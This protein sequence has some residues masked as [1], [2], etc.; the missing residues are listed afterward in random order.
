MPRPLFVTIDG[1]GFI[2]RHRET[3]QPVGEV[4]REEI[5]ESYPLPFTASFIAGEIDEY[6]ARFEVEEAR[7]ILSLDNVE[8]AS[9]SWSHPHDWTEPAIDLE[10]E[11]VASAARIER[12]LL[13]P[14]GR[15][16]LMLWTGMC[17]PT[18]AA[19]ALADALGMGNLNGGDPD[20]AF[21]E[22]D[23]YRHFCSRG[24]ND[25][26]LMD[27]GRLTTRSGR[28]VEELLS[29]FAGRLDG[30]SKAIDSFE[31]HPE[32]PVHVYFHWYSGARRD[33]MDALRRVLDWC[34]ERDDLEPMFASHYLA[35]Q[36]DEE[37]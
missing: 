26:T 34:V 15:V 8:A 20:R 9:H 29:N 7:R 2:Y 19:L 30:F 22:G 13:P 14:G 11:I 27:L 6:A 5:L 17:N 24:P 3:R 33:S 31:Q 21:I 32:R 16:K 18:I 36:G 12:Q 23:G 37:R 1:D 35:R 10:R 25:W 28:G 4:I